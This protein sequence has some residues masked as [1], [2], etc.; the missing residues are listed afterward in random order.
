[1][2]WRVLLNSLERT[3]A[4][5]TL[6]RLSLAVDQLGPIIAAILLVPSMLGMSLLSGYAG[7]ALA[8]TPGGAPTFQVLRYLAM[9]ATGMSIIG[10]IVLPGMDRTNPVRLL[11]L[12]IPR[13]TLYLALAAGAL[14]E[15][16]TLLLLPI[17]I[18][19][20]AGL[21]VGG[22]V[23]AAAMALIAG[24][25]FVIVLL[26]LSTLTSSIVQIVLRDR[27][28][29]ELI[30]LA[31]ILLLPLAGMLTSSFNPGPSRRHRTGQSAPAAAT[32]SLSSQVS[33]LVLAASPSEQFV[34]ATQAAVARRTGPSLAAWLAL[35]ATGAFLHGAAFVA[36]V[37]I[38]AFP[39]SVA[40]RR[41]SGR[42]AGAGW[43]LPLLSPG[44][45]AV[46]AAHIRLTMRSP[47]G[48][49]TLLS[50]LM[51]CIALGVIAARGGGRVPLMP[52]TGLGFALLGAL[53]SIM[54]ALPLV[55][56][57]FAI[58][59][60]GLTLELLSPLSEDDILNGKA[61]GAG[62]LSAIPAL[63]AMSAAMLLYPGGSIAL[64]ISVPLGMACVWLLVA[65]VAA[66]LACVFPKV[67]DLNSIGNRS[68]AHGVANLAG[69]A[70]TAVS[71]LPPVGIALIA[72]SLL[73]RPALA[74][75][76][77]LGWLAVAFG[78][79]RLLARPVRALLARRRENLALVVG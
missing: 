69:L 8:T 39:G 56:N 48:R 63:I 31:F 49:S 62:L 9:A 72:T 65:P 23:A 68:N 64:W 32:S 14:A 30:A 35:V 37:R 66:G 27:R 18:C 74:P 43:R 28:R 55:T 3:G 7:Y 29:G 42:Q 45:S 15:P 61:V 36:F 58:D 11:L 46:A 12:P 20:P 13:P 41:F 10:P 78:I 4:R 54:T 5:D 51:L 6:E 77:L 70:I 53:T 57:Q 73:E 52:T 22:N 50:P 25:T 71:T 60:A 38:L 40:R 1:M 75:P 2:R 44:A 79:N 47:R 17:A 26:G 34:A 33:R 59:G 67:V 19:L 16:W 21:A 76:L 24:V